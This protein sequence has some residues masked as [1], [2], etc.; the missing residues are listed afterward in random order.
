M[1]IF[2]KTSFT[3]F[4]ASPQKSVTFKEHPDSWWSTL[5][6]EKNKSCFQIFIARDLVC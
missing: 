4:K 5:Q 1:L 3:F 6:V 2:W